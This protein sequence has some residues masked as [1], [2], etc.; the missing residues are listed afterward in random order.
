MTADGIQWDFDLLR[1]ICNDR[2]LELIKIV[3]IPP[4]PGNDSWFWFADEKCLFSVRRCYRMLQGELTSI[5]EHFWKKL[6]LLKIQGKVGNFLWRTCHG[7][8]PNNQ[9]FVHEAC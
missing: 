7:C 3:P 5:Y 4:V 8:L 1:D 2:D 6:W 9:C